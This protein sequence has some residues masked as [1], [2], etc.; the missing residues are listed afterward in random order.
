MTPPRHRPRC[1]HPRSGRQYMR[2]TR[3]ALAV[4]AAALVLATAVPASAAPG[5]TPAS[6]TITGGVLSIAV[7]TDPVSLGTRSSADGGGTVNGSLGQVDRDRQARRSGGV[8]GRTASVADQPPAAATIEAGSTTATTEDIAAAPAETGP[9]PAAPE[10]AAAVVARHR[11]HRF[12]RR[13]RPV[14]VRFGEEEFATIELAAGRAG[15]T[16]T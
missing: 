9:P 4:P 13:R 7:S 10:G 5:A 8:D 15:L 1:R 3:V 16:P 11:E 2:M 14:Q 12:P 6:I